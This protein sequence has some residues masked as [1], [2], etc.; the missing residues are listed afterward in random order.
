[1]EN[2]SKW[3]DEE[4]KTLFK[5]VEIKKQEGMP[6]IKIFAEYATKTLRHANSVR[7]YYYNKD[8]TNELDFTSSLLPSQKKTKNKDIL[9]LVAL[10][11]FLAVL[12]IIEYI[13]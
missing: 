12:I 10:I 2:Y 4:I 8:K 6:L 9:E 13:Y 1:M 5:F 3:D 11:I 7:N